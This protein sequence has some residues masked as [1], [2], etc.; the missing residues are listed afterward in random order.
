MQ[1]TILI[2]AP[3]YYGI[4]TD[5]QQAF[6]TL[7]FRSLL[8]NY[9]ERKILE[10]AT[11]KI[12]DKLTRLKPILIPLR[13]RALKEENDNFISAI[14][15]LKPDVLFI[16]KGDSIFPDTLEKIKKLFSCPVVNYIWDEPLYAHSENK[17]DYRKFNLQHGLPLYDTVFVFDSFYLDVLKRQGAKRVHYLPLATNPNRYKDIL[18]S[19]QDKVAYGYDVCFVG[20]PFQSRLEILECLSEY[21]MGVFGDSWTKYFMVR[22]KK[23]PPYYRGLASGEVVNKIYLASRIV[24]N[25]H[26]SQSVAGLNTRTFDIP[27]CGAFEIVDYKKIIENHFAIDKEIVSFKDIN[28]LKSKID[29]YLKNDELRKS[30]SLQ[31]QRKV[32][33]EHTWVHR[34]QEV[35]K[36]L[37]I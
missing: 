11:K 7:G 19:D 36:V 14:S 8:I 5:I 30:I 26:H 31:G 23:T 21:N 20:V 27:A 1:K 15:E 35:L 32:L 29:F 24:L 12:G 18:L 34:A 4:D 16:V 17:D 3:Q 10:R 25:M 6:E 33:H 2:I 28:E 9:A 22:G 37:S 13:R